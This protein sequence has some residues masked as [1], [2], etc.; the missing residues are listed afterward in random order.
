MVSEE[1]LDELYD[2]IQTR[3]LSGVF[4]LLATRCN[5][6]RMLLLKEANKNSSSLNY[7][8]EEEALLESAAIVLIDI[9]EGY[10]KKSH[11]D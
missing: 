1:C 2:H 11:A 9:E 10:D 4:R 6:D 3:S 5:D 7:L 8:S